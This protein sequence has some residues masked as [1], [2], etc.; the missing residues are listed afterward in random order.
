MTNYKLVEQDYEWLD[1]I[2]QTTTSIQTLYQKLFL[3]EVMGR[4]DTIEYT[5]LL[6]YLN[7]AL[8]VEEQ[9]YCSAYLDNNKSQ[10]LIQY[11]LDNKVPDGFKNDFESILMLDYSNIVLRRVLNNLNYNIAFDYERI[12]KSLSKDLI[13]SMRKLGIPN[14]QEVIFQAIY[15]G[16]ELKRA[17]EKD[18]LVGFL[19]F[20]DE[21]VHKLDYQSFKKDLL[22]VKYNM[23]FVYKFLENDMVNNKFVVPDV[24]TFSSTLV[25]DVTQ[26]DDDFYVSLKDDYGEKASVMQISALLQVSDADYD[27]GNEIITAILRECMLRSSFLFMSDEALLNLNEEF[28]DFVE[29]RE[30]LQE[31]PNNQISEDK[32]IKCFRSIKRDRNKLVL[33]LNDRKR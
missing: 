4:K 14:F 10:A 7:I 24:F 13:N 2:I 26:T 31:Y 12:K 25:R 19:V 30:Y 23:S 15:S 6:D 5:K 16:A 28:H 21:C 22:C 29:S 27:N 32:I 3:L 18:I 20:L 9:T 1:K 33:S 8:E 11:I 17:F